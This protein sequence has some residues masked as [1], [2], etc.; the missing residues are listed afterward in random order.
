MMNN[1][2]IIL[3]FCEVE[4]RSLSGTDGMLHLSMCLFLFSSLTLAHSRSLSS[5]SRCL[6]G[7]VEK[8][9]TPAMPALRQQATAVAKWNSQAATTVS[10][11][12]ETRPSC[13][14]AN[15]S[16]TFAHM[17]DQRRHAPRFAT[18]ARQS[19]PSPPP[20]RQPRPQPRRRHQYHHHG[21]CHSNGCLPR[22]PQKGT[23]T[24]LEDTCTYS[25]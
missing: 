4:G 14:D 12:Q 11:A 16:C 21:R 15:V 22:P 20:P 3:S 25:S 10:N 7:R 19:G 24:I 13:T 6:L 9:R 18:A 17:S 8:A 5:H 2:A 1:N 23:N